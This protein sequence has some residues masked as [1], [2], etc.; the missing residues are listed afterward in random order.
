VTD[1][2]NPILLAA[3][4]LFKREGLPP[5]PIPSPLASQVRLRSSWHF[6][7]RTDTPRLYDYQ[8]YV[9]EFKTTP[10]AD[11]VQFGQ[12]GHGFASYAVHYYLAYGPI[13]LA[14]QS[15]WGSGLT[16]PRA[17]TRR[18][19]TLFAS[20]A[21]FVA[22][23]EHRPAQVDRRLLVALSDHSGVSLTWLYRDGQSIVS[24]DIPVRR[25]AGV[26][27]QARARLNAPAMQG[28]APVPEPIQVD[29]SGRGAAPD[30]MTASDDRP[31]ND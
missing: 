2:S 21:H 11:Y 31:I 14:L 27:E 6:G 1:Q 7:T 22:L 15:T 23:V 24:E 16:D 10:V 19:S 5:P 9:D 18:I 28:G 13:A 4:A 12:D 17:A 8:W 30:P 29:H 20:V 25:E 26:F 3:Q